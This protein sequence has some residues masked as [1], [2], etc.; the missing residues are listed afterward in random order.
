MVARKGTI[1]RGTAEKK[2]N[3][4]PT[5][6]ENGTVAWEAA[7]MMRAGKS[8]REVAAKLDITE[9]RVMTVMTDALKSIHEEISTVLNNWT[10]LSLSREEEIISKLW[11]NMFDEKGIP[12]PDIIGMV[13]DCISMEQKILS[14]SAAKLDGA[15]GSSIVQNVTIV[16]SGDNGLYMEAQRAMNMNMRTEQGES[17]DEDI[18]S[19]D[20]VIPGGIVYPMQGVKAKS[21]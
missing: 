20:D 13:Q 17:K 14:F 5:L 16:N 19:L 6:V 18:L 4:L 11:D 21:E 8:V 1:S 9:G 7:K 15:K 12:N 2:Q 3:K 10:V